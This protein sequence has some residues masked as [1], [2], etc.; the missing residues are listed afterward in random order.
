MPKLFFNAKSIDALKPGD[1]PIEYWDSM[2]PGFGIRVSTRGVKTWTL[3]YRY[4][5]RLRRLGLGRHSRV[6][7]ADARQRAKDGLFNTVFRVRGYQPGQRRFT[8]T[9][10]TGCLRLDPSHW[11]RC[12]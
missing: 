11:G 8:I 2:L 4:R 5:G 12:F 6:S 9:F 3:L 1:R 10:S 7:L